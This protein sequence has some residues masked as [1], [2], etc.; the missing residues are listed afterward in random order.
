MIYDGM[1]SGTSR[2]WPP[3]NTNAGD[4]C[5][6]TPTAAT[7]LT[8]TCGVTGKASYSCPESLLGSGVVPGA[9]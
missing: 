5:A 7:F 9:G 4:C 6:D 1:C 8:R 3:M 2:K